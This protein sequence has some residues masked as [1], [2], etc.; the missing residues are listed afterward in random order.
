MDAAVNSKHLQLLTTSTKQ[1]CRVFEKRCVQG[2]WEVSED[3]ET[4]LCYHQQMTAGYISRMRV[5]SSPEVVCVR[6]I[7]FLILSSGDLIVL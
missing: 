3:G 7:F 4:R 1:A 6:I 2:R 5:Q